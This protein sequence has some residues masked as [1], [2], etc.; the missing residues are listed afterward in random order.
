MYHVAICEDEEVVRRELCALT[1]KVLLSLEI[2]G[3]I[4]AF[5]SAEA[6]ETVLAEQARPFD[7]LLLDIQLGGKTG[8]E[9]ARELR[10]RNDRVGIIFTTSCE[11]YLATGYGVQPIH[12]LLKPVKEENLRRAIQT[13]WRVNHEVKRVTLRDGPRTAVVSL[14]DIIFF[15]SRNHDV[16]AHQREGE[17]L[18]R[19]PLSEVE[20]ALPRDAFCRCHKS[21]LVNYDYIVGFGRSGVL[22][23][24]GESVPIG[25]KF[26]TTAKNAFIHYIN[27]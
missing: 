20:E 3:E 12:F 5:S 1:E 22:L 10:D 2:P 7:L 19:L 21:F 13:D 27:R 15:E 16:V 9:L 18:L 23:N 25:R 14:R 11:E 26:L 6:L 24:T 8:L 17:R 4:T